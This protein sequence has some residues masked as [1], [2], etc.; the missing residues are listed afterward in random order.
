MLLSSA[1]GNVSG[2]LGGFFTSLGYEGNV[3]EPM[4]YQGQAAGHYS[5]GSVVLR[6]QVKNI[7]LINLDLPSLKAGCGGIDLFGGGFSFVN[8]QAITEFFQKIMSNAT[9]YIFKLALQTAVPQ[10]EEVMKSVQSMAQEINATNFNSCEMAQNL[11]GGMWPRMKATQEHICKDIGSNQ[12]NFFSD[13]ADARQGCSEVNQY[14]KAMDAAAEDPAYKKAVIVNKNLIW[15]ALI[16]NSNIGEH[17]LVSY[18]YVGE[19]KEF[20]MSLSGTIIYGNEGKVNI[21]PPLAKDRE[22]LKAMLAGGSA[23]I[24]KCDEK[25]KCLKPSEVTISISAEKALYAKISRTIHE[26]VAA[27][28][29]D[30]GPLSPNL[31]TFLEM[32]KL[33]LLKFI[34]V[35]LM[36]G[37]VAMAM[38]IANYSEI[39][40]KSLLL[41]YMHE[42]LQVVEH[43]L[44]G[45]DYAPDIHKQLTDQIHQAL[46]F[47]EKIKT[48][49]SNDIQELMTF[50]E[51]SQGVEREVTSRVTG[52]IKPHLGA[53]K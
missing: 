52:S 12:R 44:S 33:P 47:V 48:E 25:D 49:S 11:V 50:I 4:A 41:Q 20:F 42:A 15:D 26:L 37:N 6:N 13:W 46:G 40:A 5:G 1:N 45:T 34:S 32:T 27:V 43:S 7:Q 3:T 2:D 53:G 18:R 10:I 28:Q 22:V 51:S 39:I 19:L 35:H 29:S 31:Q 8:A 30:S 17:K 24:Y 16:N 36:N 9:G 23:N 14:N 38:S 21:F